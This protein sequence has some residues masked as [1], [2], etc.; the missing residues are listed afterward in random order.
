MPFSRIAGVELRKMFDTR[1]G[2]W[3]LMSIGILALLASG[4]V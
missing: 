4:A 1:S 3:L 2:F